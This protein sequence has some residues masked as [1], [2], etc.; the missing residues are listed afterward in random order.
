MTA[1]STP[2]H[3]PCWTTSHGDRRQRS[4]PALP[5]PPGTS[6]HVVHRF[7]PTLETHG[8]L[9]AERHLTIDDHGADQ[10]RLAVH[11]RA[12]KVAVEP[13]SIVI[14]LLPRPVWK[15]LGIDV[16]QLRCLDDGHAG[17]TATGSDSVR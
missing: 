12:D 4:T 2:T 6:V 11:S 14:G 9:P 8:Q 7:L 17:R 16:T 10:Y 3:S 1:S 5:G 13:A 15:R